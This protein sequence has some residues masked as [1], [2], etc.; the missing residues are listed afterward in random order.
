MARP[1]VI[2]VVS[3][4]T[5]MVRCS[6]VAGGR[7][8][9]PGAGSASGASVGPGAGVAYAVSP[10]SVTLASNASTTINVTMTAGK[11]VA[12]GAYQDFLEV[13]VGGASVAHAAVFTLIK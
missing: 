13:K 8:P 1:P 3:T 6:Y 7:G 2:P 4:E 9:A 10:A 11:G 12:P 5:R